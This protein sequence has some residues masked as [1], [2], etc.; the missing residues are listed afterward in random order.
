MARSHP[1]LALVTA[2]YLVMIVALTFVGGDDEHP[3]SPIWSLGAFLVLGALLT[4]LS[5]P[6]RWWVA[7]GFGVLGAAWI[8]A[9]QTVWRP[10]GYASVMDLALGALGVA[11][12]VGLVVAVRVARARQPVQHPTAQHSTAQLDQSGG[13]HGIL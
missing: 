13:Q 9:A 12:G 8:E 10:A 7:L 2:L 1:I 6:R 4:V 5:S 11:I 3:P